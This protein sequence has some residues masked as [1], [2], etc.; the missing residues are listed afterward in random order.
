MNEKCLD[1]YMELLS[2]E[3]TKGQGTGSAGKPASSAGKGRA[4]TP[5]SSD[6]DGPARQQAQQFKKKR[7]DKVIK[8]IARSKSLFMSFVRHPCMQTPEGFRLLL[9]KLKDY[10]KSFAYQEMVKQSEKRTKANNT[11]KEA[12]RCTLHAHARTA[13]ERPEPR[14]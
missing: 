3:S 12:H 10:K 8:H 13:G 2:Q 1:Q 9:T 14:H 11:Q 6:G 7:F 5:A 4:G